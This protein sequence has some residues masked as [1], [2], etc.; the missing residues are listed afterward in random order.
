[1]FRRSEG[2]ERSRRRKGIARN[3]LRGESCCSVGC[4]DRDDRA[5]SLGFAAAAGRIFD[6]DDASHRAAGV[7]DTF[8][9]DEDE[10]VVVLMLAVWASSSAAAAAALA[11]LLGGD[12]RAVPK[13]VSSTFTLEE[14]A[15]FPVAGWCIRD[16]CAAARALSLRWWCVDR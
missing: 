2:G 9:E 14:D 6:D 11:V 13:G 15:T 4:A 12:E 3:M 16:D 7:G 10:D 1:M 5:A 8:G